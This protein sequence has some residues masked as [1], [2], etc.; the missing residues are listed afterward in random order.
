MVRET[1]VALDKKQL[2]RGSREGLEAA[3]RRMDLVLDLF[4]R[5][6]VS[7]DV[8][9]EELIRRREAARESRDF[10]QADRIRD[11]LAARGILLEDTPEGTVWK[12][13]LG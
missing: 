7:L 10:A 9:I 6:E 11:E 2:P 8:E 5:P 3:S 4:D 13:R 1:H 12:R